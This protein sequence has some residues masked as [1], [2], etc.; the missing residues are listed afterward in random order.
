[1]SMAVVRWL[2]ASLPASGSRIV[3]VPAS[4][5][6]LSFTLTCTALSGNSVSASTQV[7]VI[8]NS[9]INYTGHWHNPSES[10]WGVT[11]AH[12]GIVEHGA[13]SG[14]G[15]EEETGPLRSGSRQKGLRASPCSGYEPFDK[16]RTCLAIGPFSTHMLYCVA[17]R[18]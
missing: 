3:N 10:G 6:N 14:E 4:V 7:S 5:G 1:M 2:V 11:I 8:V 15:L 17:I 18:C 16:L 13:G 9:N 12:Q